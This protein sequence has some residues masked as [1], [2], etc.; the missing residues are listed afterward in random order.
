MTV[1]TAAPGRTPYDEWRDRH[2]RLV[3]LLLGVMVV[4]TVALMVTMGTRPATYG[5]LLDDVASSKVREV[6]VVG[7]D[8]PAP[9]DRVE[10]R[11]TVLAGVLDQYT[12]VQVGGHRGHDAWDEPVFVSSGDPQRTLRSINQD[13]IISSGSSAHDPSFTFMEW[14]VPGPLALLALAIWLGVLLLIIGGPE[15]WRA[16]RWAWGWAWLLTGPLGSVAYLLLGGPSGLAAPRPRHRR[17]TGG[18]AL[19]LAWL[20]FGGWRARHGW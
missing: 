20:L 12:V 9:G 19:V 10:L 5:D 1:E 4:V 2:W 17:I 11:W 7:A 3:G 14:R 15:P 18:L 13:V 16:T 6:Q 8:A